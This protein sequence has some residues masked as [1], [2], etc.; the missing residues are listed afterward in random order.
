[1]GVPGAISRFPRWDLLWGQQ[2][3][4]HGLAEKWGLQADLQQPTRTL[5]PLLGDHLVTMGVR[6]CY[7]QV[8]KLSTLWGPSGEEFAVFRPPT[9]P[10][11]LLGAHLMT[12][13][14]RIS[15]GLIV[16]WG[17][18]ELWPLFL[19]FFIAT[20]SFSGLFFS[21]MVS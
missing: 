1:M 16:V 17:E 18:T 21:Q 2:R 10:R 15:C 14:V 20:F 7:L 6:R 11:P 8:S 13:G 19:L 4:P 5:E 12:M 3:G 9:T